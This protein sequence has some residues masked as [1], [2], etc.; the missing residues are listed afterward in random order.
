MDFKYKRKFV[1]EAG[2]N[3][4]ESKCY[5]KDGKDL[6]IMVPMGTIVRS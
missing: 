4:G 1:A 2:E 6:E 5:G 3:G